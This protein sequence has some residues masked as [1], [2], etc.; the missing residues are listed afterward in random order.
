MVV[1]NVG[2]DTRVVSVRLCWRAV[3]VT[4]PT[5]VY[6]CHRTYGIFTFG[7]GLCALR[8][9][10]DFYRS[11]SQVVRRWRPRRGGVLY[12]R[13]PRTSTSFRHHMLTCEDDDNDIPQRGA[14]ILYS[15]VYNTRST[16]RIICRCC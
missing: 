5:R 11:P 2:G 12:P 4:V 10:S 13:A 15:C 7:G 16:V 3:V 1:L 8:R 6:T 9:Q 14:Q